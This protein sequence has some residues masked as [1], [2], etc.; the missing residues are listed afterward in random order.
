MKTNTFFRATLRVL[1][2]LGLLC[3]NACA[4]KKQEDTDVQIE[5]KD[6]ICNVREYRK[7]NIRFRGRPIE[8]G[9]NYSALL[10]GS[11]N[12][13]YNGTPHL[14]IKLPDGSKA[15]LAEISVVDLR[16]KASGISAIGGHI[17]ID[18]GAGSMDPGAHWPEGAQEFQ[19]H[20]WKFVVQNDKILSFSVSFRVDKNWPW[21]GEKP[22][23][24]IPGQEDLYDFPLNQTQVVNLLGKSGKIYEYLEE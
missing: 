21:P 12:H 8:N 2:L 19:M 5:K 14:L 4:K 13:P 17:F 15:D 11:P 20:A 6:W 1:P 23:I 18:I 24:G 22:A 10:I 3:L 9:K 7:D 16:K